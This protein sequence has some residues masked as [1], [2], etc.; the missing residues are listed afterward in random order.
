LGVILKHKYSIKSEKY[1]KIIKMSDG[2]C[3]CKCQC[4][5]TCKARIESK[6]LYEY[7]F[8]KKNTTNN[9]NKC[10]TTKRPASP[11]P[12]LEDKLPM[13]KFSKPNHCCFIPPKQPTIPQLK[14]QWS[15][16]DEEE[17]AKEDK[18]QENKKEH[19]YCFLNMSSQYRQCCE[20][21]QKM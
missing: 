11:I 7:V 4:N 3:N 17:K 10:L 2:C 9:P 16:K 18:N 20:Q 5:I 6:E 21:C 12:Q 1:Q 15:K 13:F 8:K 14:D 19:W